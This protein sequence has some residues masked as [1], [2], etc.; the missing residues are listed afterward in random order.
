MEVDDPEGM[1]Q[2]YNSKIEELQ[3]DI[4]FL[5]HFATMVELVERFALN[6]LVW[7]YL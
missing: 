5:K 7:F 6:K 3:V 1:K 2:Y 4:C